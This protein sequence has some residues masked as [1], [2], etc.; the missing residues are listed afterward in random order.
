MGVTCK[1]ETGEGL[2]SPSRW[3]GQ[4]AVVDTLMLVG[5]RAVMGDIA[6]M[7]G[8]PI[9]RGANEPAR[10]QQQLNNDPQCAS[11]RLSM[12]PAPPPRGYSCKISASPPLLFFFFF[13]LEL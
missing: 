11:F 1:T 8:R 13:F 12:L 6:L 5:D 2:T 10:H 3:D 7:R 4:R 9:E